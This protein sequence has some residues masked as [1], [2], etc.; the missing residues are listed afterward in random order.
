MGHTCTLLGFP[1]AVD[2]DLDRYLATTQL[3]LTMGV[4]TKEAA[5]ARL[6][7]GDSPSPWAGP[8]LRTG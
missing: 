3:A 8:S 1:E 6:T 4:L 7:R 5:F 2:I